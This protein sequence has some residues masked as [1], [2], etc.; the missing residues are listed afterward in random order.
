M[1]DGER[2]GAEKGSAAFLGGNSSKAGLPS[3]G[4]DRARIDRIIEEASKGS[5]FFEYQRRREERIKGR[6]AALRKQMELLSRD[7]D[8]IT[9][10]AEQ[11]ES[12]RAE[13][14]RLRDLESTFI[15][16]DMDG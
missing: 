2:L 16:V 6:C 10:A 15:H 5:K 11:V 14:E 1:E 9:R 8:A 13:L 12:W 4:L 3:D 7:P